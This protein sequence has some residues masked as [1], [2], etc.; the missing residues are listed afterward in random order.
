[1]NGRRSRHAFEIYRWPLLVALVIT[2]G[3]GAALTGKQTGRLFSWF[4]LGLPLIVI[5]A[6]LVAVTGTRKHE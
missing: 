2:L 3:L 1:M 5:L 6:C 4:A